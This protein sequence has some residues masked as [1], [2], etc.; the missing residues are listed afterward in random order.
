MNPGGIGAS[1]LRKEDRRFLLGK[2]RYTDD[3]NLPHQAHACIVRSPHA[4]ARV[5]SV[6]AT[7]ALAVPGVLAVFTGA[8]MAADQ[9]G[10]LPCGWLIT[11]KGGKPMVEPPHPPLAADRVRYVGDQVAVVV[12]ETRAQAKA[13]ARE[14]EVEYET[15]PA[16]VRGGEAAAPGAPLVWEQAPGNVCFDWGIGDAAAVD[17][18]LA[19]AHKV[20]EIELTNNRL[21]PNPM[22]PRAAIGDYDEAEDRYTLY[23]TS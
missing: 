22:E 13:G 7:R 6:D 17:A 20:V 2:G 18:A 15:L 4:H 16:A 9:I 3:L 23:T 8:D 14:L 5:A 21:V 11:G 19:G 1:V 12:A 10:G